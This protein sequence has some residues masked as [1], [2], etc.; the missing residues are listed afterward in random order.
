MT[1]RLFIFAAYDKDN[2]IDN[3]LL[4]YLRALSKLGD[5]VFTMDNDTPK[6]EMK[7]LSDIPNILHA[8]AVRHN[9]YDF[10]SYK[11]GYIWAYDKKILE[12]YDWVYFVNDSVYGPLWDIERLLN[13]LESQNINVVG[14]FENFSDNIPRHIQSWFIGLK[15]TVV[16]QDFFYNF[17]KNISHQDDKSDIVLKYEVGLTRLL[18]QNGY[19]YYSFCK[20][21]K[22]DQ[23]ECLIYKDPLKALESGIPFVKKSS[24]YNIKSVKFLYPYTSEK[25]I[26]DILNHAKRNNLYIKSEI[27]NNY[28][29]R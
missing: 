16:Q 2:I 18:I 3:T 8:V 19:K 21:I 4:Y 12:K 5:I 15:N 28:V 22:S 6:S 27:L 29:I 9:E 10:G 7:K 20:N 11:R 13:N 14:I 23:D 17:I 26:K 25:I 1:K 24:F